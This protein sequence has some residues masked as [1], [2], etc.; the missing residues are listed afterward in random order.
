MSTALMAGYHNRL[1]LLSIPHTSSR[2]LWEIETSIHPNS[3]THQLR[4]YL[5]AIEIQIF[6]GMGNEVV[7][8]L[9]GE[10]HKFLVLKRIH[11]LEYPP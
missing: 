11:Y 2:L 6:E 1:G 8:Q 5:W 7:G 10:V 3:T 9:E 4:D